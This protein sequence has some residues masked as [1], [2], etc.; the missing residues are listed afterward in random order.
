MGLFLECGR[1]LQY[2]QKTNTGR[3][4]A[5]T[6]LWGMHANHY[7]HALN[8]K[9]FEKT[10]MHVIQHSVHENS[11]KSCLLC[12]RCKKNDA[13]DYLHA[14]FR[15][16]ALAPLCIIFSKQVVPCEVVCECESGHADLCFVWSGWLKDSKSIQSISHLKKGTVYIIR[17]QIM[18]LS[19]LELK[20]AILNLKQG[21]IDN[22]KHMKAQNL[23]EYRKGQRKSRGLK[24]EKLELW[25]LICCY[26]MILN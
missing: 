1:I 22:Q 14:Y 16:C 19:I 25:V 6:F 17:Y 26:L 4:R 15:H 8:I 24:S 21:A 10:Q 9:C 18:M 13:C 2:C 5:F 7:H 23:S 20:N 12:S 11:F 3:R